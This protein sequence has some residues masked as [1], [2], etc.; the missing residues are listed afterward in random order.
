M[1]E[2]EILNMRIPPPKSEKLF[3]ESTDRNKLNASI[4]ESSS[5]SLVAD[6]KT[7]VST[8]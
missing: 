6:S 4:K 5:N 3:R 2:K 8:N 7:T 1:T